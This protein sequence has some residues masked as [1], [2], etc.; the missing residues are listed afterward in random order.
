[1]CNWCEGR[2]LL[3]NLENEIHRQD[4]MQEMNN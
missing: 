1:M 4:F 2:E 3:Y